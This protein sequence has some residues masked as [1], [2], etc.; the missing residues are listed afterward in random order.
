MAPKRKV[1]ELESR[2]I[3]TNTPEKMVVPGEETSGIVKY[4]Q[5]DSI[6]NYFII[7]IND[8]PDYSSCASN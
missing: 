8:S 6:Y 7:T 2:G 3:M 1:E 5:V 4:I